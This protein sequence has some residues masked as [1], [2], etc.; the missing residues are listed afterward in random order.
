VT[1]LAVDDGAG[2]AAGALIVDAFKGGRRGLNGG[3]AG[4]RRGR[5]QGRYELGLL[6]VEVGA[7]I[8]GVVGGAMAREREEVGLGAGES[9]IEDEGG[10]GRR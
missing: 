1:W 10:G 6:V 4:W 5:R 9:V 8:G 7:Q 2:M 3:W